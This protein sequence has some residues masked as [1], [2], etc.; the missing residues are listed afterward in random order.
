MS[1]QISVSDQFKTLAD[2]IQ[3]HKEFGT[4]GDACDFIGQVFTSRYKAVRK[5]DEKKKALKN[6]KPAKKPAKKAKA[7]K[8]KA[9]KA[10]PVAATA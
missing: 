7:K 4:L 8:A 6:G 1:V 5:Y 9:K 3:K 10:A 2:K